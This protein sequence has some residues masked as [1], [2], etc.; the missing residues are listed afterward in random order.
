M[1][2]SANRKV[3]WAYVAPVTTWQPSVG[4]IL[5]LLPIAVVSVN[6]DGVVLYANPMLGRLLDRDGSVV[7][8]DLDEVT[9][10]A[11][12]FATL[13][14]LA[15]AGVDR[16]L[17]LRRPDGE[18]VWVLA[19]ARRADD[20]G[21][22]VA[23]FVDVTERHRAA[24][25]HEEAAE[26]LTLLAELPERN[27]GPV[28]RLTRDGTVLMANAA[29]RRFIGERDIRGRS[30]IAVC[31]GM[32]WEIWEKVLASDPGS[33]VRVLHEAERAGVCVLFTHLRSESGDLVFVYGADITARRR[34]EQLLAEKT[35][36]LAEVAR[37]PEMNPGP[38]L[39][40]SREGK[41]LMANAAARSV[42]G[43]EVVGRNWTDM[44]PGLDVGTWVAMVD[45]A[46]V[47]PFEA[48][49]RDRDFVFAHRFD[50]RTQLMFVFGAD[51]SAQKL[52]ERALRQ[53]EKMAT[54]GTLAAGVAHE[55]N[56]PAAA[57]RRAA[58]HLRDAFTRLEAARLEIESCGRDVDR[59]LLRE[60]DMRARNHAGR[61]SDL[62][63]V[64]RSDR[65]ADLEDW[66]DHHGVDDGWELAPALVALGIDAA[67]LDGLEERLG[68]A[69]PAVMVWVANAFRV[70]MLA[71]EIGQGSA[72]ISEIVGALKGYSYLG[73][74]PVQAV[75]V[76]EGLD[77][78]L[79]IL[80][81][82]LKAGVDV[83]RDYGADVPLITAYG[84]ELNQVW[85]NILD[86]AVDAMAGKGT[87]TIRTRR[88]GDWVV[89]EVVDDG[90]GI[91]REIL[92]KVFDP[93][94][95]TKD[96]GKGTGLG[97]ATSYSIVTEK[98]RGSI[99]VTSQPGATRFVVRLPIDQGTRG[100]EGQ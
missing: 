88:D 19:S 12:V 87:I 32:T 25:E 79:V 57:T 50:P 80:R 97:L 39:R 77:N 36:Q 55:L 91:P 83:V 31:P 90:P 38:V 21:S 28:C 26:A 64:E 89:V 11:D 10:V 17:C 1:V 6:N 48:R 54:L 49:V 56:N 22:V 40:M 86:N 45:A 75:D 51:V 96:P 93:F 94:F 76:H 14:Y 84:G 4:D 92:G 82:K 24:M 18:E 72:R 46:E 62:G 23:T 13:T 27:P 61:P 29:A 44:C 60:L 52:A 99:A 69:L 58:E 53:S 85:T 3:G 8:G 74:A 68:E 66:L 100:Q 33:D 63:T 67:Q 78:T 73:Q 41:V 98:H 81:N 7:G 5:G 42:F 30:W 9:G 71:H 95:T 16:E 2:A 47:R 20:D 15:A 59:Q 65:E 34:H 35:A 37:F 43:E 70:H